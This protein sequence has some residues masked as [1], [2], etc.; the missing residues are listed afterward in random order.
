MEQTIPLDLPEDL[1]GKQH[2][3]EKRRDELLERFGKA[4]RKQ[5]HSRCRRLFRELHLIN[6]VLAFLD[7]LAADQAKAKSKGQPKSAV[8]SLFLHHCFKELTAD[9]R[10]QFFFITGPEI[11]GTLM[12]NQRIEFAH[13]KRSVAGASGDTGSTHRLLMMLEAFKHRLLGHFHSH[14]GKGASATQPS[15]ID[16]N[17]QRRLEKAGHVGVAAIFSHD[18]WVR[19]FRLDRQVDINIFGEGVE[20]HE[21]K[22]FRLTNLDQV[23]RQGDP[24]RS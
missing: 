3:L 11:D 6:Q 5:K 16:E 22:L 18:G 10:E 23:D 13:E 4:A 12:L 1:T 17:F 24:G 14:P 7:Q 15:G 20:R 21:A 9:E 2:E 19:F 8:S